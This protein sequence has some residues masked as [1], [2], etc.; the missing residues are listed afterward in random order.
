MQRVAASS[1]R[2][3]LTT[4]GCRRHAV[5]VADGADDLRLW[6]AAACGYAG[7]ADSFYRRVHGFLWDRL[8]SV[9][10]LDVLDLGCGEGWLAEEMRLAGARVTGID[11]SA[12]LLA[13]ARSQYPQVVFEQRDLVLGL[14]R[15][16]PRFDRIVAHMVL[17]DI[18][19]LDRLLA[20]VA[21]A[22]R[23]GGVFV[24][25][26][27]H[28][29]FF[30]RAVVDEGPGGQRYRRVTGYLEHETRWI[31]TFGGHRHYHR[32]LSWYVG[33][34]VGQGLVI[35][36]LHEPPSL[37]PAETPEADW[38]GYQKWFS[39]IPTALAISCRTSGRVIALRWACSPP[40]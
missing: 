28:P 33:Q 13:R 40:G 18:P 29:A 25:T 37:P 17:M 8:G 22:L 3:G 1:G 6:N 34:L 30:S 21:A 16:S 23:P 11:G 15:P 10:G 24:F 31:T 9:Q 26:I 27:L 14:P 38:T 20:D 32:P 19:D 35:T 5:H 2:P 36:G 4:G 39:T 12:V 7:R